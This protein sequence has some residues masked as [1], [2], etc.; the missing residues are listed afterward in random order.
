MSS[1]VRGSKPWYSLRASLELARFVAIWKLGAVLVLVSISLVIVSAGRSVELT[2]RR[3]PI[4]AV[5]RLDF[6]LNVAISPDTR[7][8]EAPPT[9]LSQHSKCWNTLTSPTSF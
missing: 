8:E 7:Q 5:G 9:M 2:H 3:S 1:R 4:K 6:K